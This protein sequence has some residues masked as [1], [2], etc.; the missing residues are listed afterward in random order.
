MFK[1]IVSLILTFGLANSAISATPGSDDLAAGEI[2][3]PGQS[4]QSKNGIYRFIFQLDG[5]LVVYKN[6]NNPI[7]SSDTHGSNADRLIMQNDG[8]FVLYSNDNVPLWHSHTGDSFGDIGIDY[9]VVMQDDGNLVLYSF[10]GDISV[11]A[12]WDS[13]GHTR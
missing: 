13:Q 2:M 1:F 11:L 3:T 6:E 5:N 7:W 9:D 10:A 4:I 8:N 12:L